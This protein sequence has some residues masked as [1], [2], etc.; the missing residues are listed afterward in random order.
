MIQPVSSTLPSSLPIIAAHS[1]TE[2]KAHILALGI[3]ASTA[4]LLTTLWE[5]AIPISICILCVSILSSLPSRTLIPA[6]APPSR[7][8]IKTAEPIYLHHPVPIRLPPPSPRT[9]SV[10]IYRPPAPSPIHRAPVG[11]GERTFAAPRPPAP[12]PSCRPPIEAGGRTYA[13]PPAAFSPSERAPVGNRN[14]SR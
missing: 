4:F 1:S 9:R 8:Y 12:Y 11:T 3:L 5:F 13:P 14:S 6:S 2:C 10:P 7:L